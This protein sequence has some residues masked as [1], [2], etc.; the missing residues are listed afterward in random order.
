MEVAHFQSPGDTCHNNPTR[1]PQSPSNRD[2][3]LAKVNS[4]EISFAEYI[5]ADVAITGSLLPI[6]DPQTIQVLYTIPSG[7]SIT[8]PE[9]LKFVRQPPSQSTEI[10]RSLSVC[11]ISDDF[12]VKSSGDELLSEAKIM[13][14]VQQH[15]SIPVPTIHLVFTVSDPV[16]KGAIITYILMDRIRGADLQHKWPSLSPSDRSS[17]IST[18]KDYVA[19]LRNI[20][21]PENCPPGPLN[22][23]RCRGPWFSFYDAGPFGSYDALIAWWNSTLD[24]AKKNGYCHSKD[25]FTARAPLVFTHGDLVARN[26]ILDGDGTVW[27][28]DWELAGWYPSYVE[29]A[30]L[31]AFTGAG[32]CPDIP[33]WREGLHSLLGQYEQESGLLHDMVGTLDR[34]FPD[35]FQNAQL[36]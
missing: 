8:A 36:S 5:F 3:L 9:V 21:L 7:T 12:L 32:G 13:L 2:D 14:F 15:T 33:E 25:S 4:G 10:T 19:Q 31:A 6:Q 16:A 35:C 27:V 1:P 23:R 22:G 11:E 20:P 18:V 34:Q 17:V 30:S 24:Y 29:Y 26:L 28:V